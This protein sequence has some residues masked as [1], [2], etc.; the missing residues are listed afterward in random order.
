M[1]QTT[2][3][4][5]AWEFVGRLQVQAFAHRISDFRRK[6]LGLV[7]PRAAVE[8]DKHVVAHI[9]VIFDLQQSW[10][11][12]IQL[13]RQLSRPWVVRAAVYFDGCVALGEPKARR[14]LQVHVPLL[15]LAQQPLAHKHHRAGITDVGGHWRLQVH[16]IPLG[17]PLSDK[18]AR[19]PLLHPFVG[20][21]LGNHCLRELAVHLCVREQQC[22]WLLAHDRTY[23]FSDA[24]DLLKVDGHCKHEDAARAVNAFGT[25]SA[26]KVFNIEEDLQ[27]WADLAAALL[28]EL[29]HILPERP[30]M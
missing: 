16:H 5:Y 20:H 29:A 13:D 2:G 28:D 8:V 4:E 25:I 9:S 14:A 15:C 24:V 27:A 21:N 18:L 11:H 23:E 10:P 6:H 30:R 7:C 1:T 3:I 19:F 22:D 12:T 17:R 26:N